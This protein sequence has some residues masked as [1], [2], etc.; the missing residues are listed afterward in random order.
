MESAAKAHSSDTQ[1]EDFR[2]TGSGVLAYRPWFQLLAIAIVVQLRED[3]PVR[4]PRVLAGWP[5]PDGKIHLLRTD[6]CCFAKSFS[7]SDGVTALLFR[8]RG[9]ESQC[10]SNDHDL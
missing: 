9:D 3:R 5:I 7:E 6:N 1:I 4:S 8:E 2:V 10:V